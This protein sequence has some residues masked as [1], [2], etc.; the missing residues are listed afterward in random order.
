MKYIIL[1]ILMI[2][3]FAISQ[4][5]L[6]G[7]V[8]FVD[9]N[10]HKPLDNVEIYWENTN[11][12]TITNTTGEFQINYS[13][14]YKKLIF[15]H[16]GFKT[17]TIEVEKNQLIIHQ[18]QEDLVLEEVQIKSKKKDFQLSHV[19]VNFG[20]TLNSG[21]LLKAACCN[22]S[23]SFGTN[24]SVDVSFTDAVTGIKQIQLLGLSSPYILFTQENIPAIKGANQLLGFG[25]IPGTWVESIQIAKGAGSVINGY[26]SITGQINFEL[27]KP[28]HKDKFF[29]NLYGSE[30]G[31]WEFNADFNKKISEH[32][33]VDLLLHT[34][35]LQ[36]KNDHNSD[37]FLDEPMGNQINI[38]NRW[39]Y[40]NPHKNYHT[41][42]IWRYLKDDRQAGQ[43]AF[44]PD[45][46]QFT[47]QFW[48]SESD[49]E[50]WDIYY[51]IGKV[52]PDLPYKSMGFQVNYSYHKQDAYYGLK[53][54][55]VKNNNLYFNY[56][57]QSVLSN[58]FHKFK[59]G[60][61]FKN[62]GYQEFVN[63]TDYSRTDWDLGTFFEYNY[64]KG[65]KLSYNA[66]VRFDY[67]NLMD[68]FVTPRLH[69]KYQLFEK[70]SLR[71]SVASGKRIANI[72]VENPQLFISNRNIIIDG[73]SK[74]AYGLKPE[75]AVNIGINVLQTF[76]LSN[77][78]GSLS[79]EFYRTDFINQVVVD[80]EN[81]QQI[82]F[83]NLNGK[84][85]AN[86]FQLSAN[87]EILKGFEVRLAYK[88]TL[89]KTQ[90]EQGLLQKP[91]QAQERFFVNTSYKSPQSEKGGYWHFDATWNHIGTM[92]LPNTSSNPVAYQTP[93]HSQPYYLVNFQVNKFIG[94]HFSLY[95]GGENVLDYTQH[96]AILANDSPFSTYF[97]GSIVYAPING[98]MF[99]TGLRYSVD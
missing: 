97:D 18:M 59:T 85:F 23:E 76:Q 67:H 3:Y 50:K 41:S 37:G 39:N 69:I 30:N 99:F 45:I 38:L 32:L 17:D 60:V 93:T 90:Y 1:G 88:N 62:D 47:T 48:G 52:Y 61:S 92:R 49:V 66:G 73:D 12:F 43:L 83:Y 24:P 40:D 89:Q 8:Y 33:G 10:Q 5:T 15:S 7:K 95:F 11:E 20:E 16:I 86:S 79:A 68:F 64:D 2:P 13:N 9:N 65:E 72:F 56:I 74:G 6:T 57:Y 34:N 28:N 53:T 55:N 54:Y 77:R 42:L 14:Q 22:L 26:E 36:T 31:R 70:T 94:N 44:D 84:S 96:N 75:N 29:F 27:K 63:Q 51:K 91:L 19:G 80:F 78:N 21:E 35:L 71:G 87:Y 98:S 58:T 46:H 4:N 81:S 25:Y 82:K